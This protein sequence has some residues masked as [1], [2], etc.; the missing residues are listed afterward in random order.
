MKEEIQRVKEE[1]V[2]GEVKDEVKEEGLRYMKE[3]QEHEE[4][5]KVEDERCF[6]KKKTK[7][8]FKKR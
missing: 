2:K 8:M 6:G 1:V 3:E 4:E 5:L 7:F